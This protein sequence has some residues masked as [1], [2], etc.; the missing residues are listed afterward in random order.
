MLTHTHFCVQRERIEMK[1]YQGASCVHDVI[2][3]WYCMVL[4]MY[5]RMEER[6]ATHVLYICSWQAKQSIA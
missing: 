3:V 4:Y 2:V 6:A 1:N 5:V